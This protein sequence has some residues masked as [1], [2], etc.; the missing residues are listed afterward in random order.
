MQTLRVALGERAYPIHI[1][2][3][4]LNAAELFA[5]HLAQKRVAI[6]TNEIVAPLYLPRLRHTLRSAGIDTLEIILPDGEEHKNWST[7]NEIFEA[8]L[9]ARAERKTTMIALG[10]GVV[11][12]VTG[13]AAATYQRGVP[14]I[15]VP[16]TLLAQVDSSVGG[17]TAINHPRGKNMIG[18]FYQPRVV[19]SDMDTLKTLPAR[20]LKAGLAEVIKHG[21]IRDA[22]FFD[23][24]EHN[25]ERLLAGDAEALGHAVLRSC[26]IKA[27]IVASDERE[28]GERALL[29]FG[30]TFGH[31]IETGLGYGTWLHGE[32][33]AA[34]MA[35][36]ADLSARL[37]ML[38]RSD[39]G[40]V[41][42]LLARAG[43]PVAVKGL[44]TNRFRELMSVD[45]KANDGRLRFILLQGIGS[46][47]IRGDVPELSVN[48]TLEAA[49]GGA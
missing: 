35:L 48:Q 18:A 9:A 15:Q 1:G 32:A 14:Y 37:G 19:V 27:A 33:V 49:A 22:T 46:A 39:A 17:K 31:A 7:L 43:L 44:A 10:G 25:V 13:F 24:L 28:E 34:G 11:G 2:S 20:E 16:T 30:H 41:T 12:D 6:V 8:L 40:R 23:W 45:K 42:S 4:L 36:A 29:N 3:G 38:A 26:E 5:P 47:S 21:A